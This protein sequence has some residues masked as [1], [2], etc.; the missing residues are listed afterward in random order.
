MEK[1]GVI[2]VGI[3][4]HLLSQRSGY[5]QAGIHNYI[6]QILQHLPAADEELDVTVFT[7]LPSSSHQARGRSTS[8]NWHTSR[9]ATDSP[10]SRILWEQF[11]QP[12]VLWRSQM[13]LLHAPAFVS[14]LLTPVPTLVT[15]HDL[16]FIRFP[17]LFR[18]LN[19]LYLSVMTRFSCRRARRIIAVSEATAVETAT[20]LDVP[21][22]RIDVIPHG[23]DHSRFRPL[24][25]ERIATFRRE[26]GL[27]DRYILFLGTLEPRKNLLALVEAYADVRLAHPDTQLVI[28]G[29]KGWYYQEIFQRVEQ[30]NLL[31]TVRFTGFVPDEELPLWY[32]AATVF[33]YPSLY[34][35]FGLPLL[36]AM[37]CGVPVIGADAS[38]T[39]DVVGTAGLLFSPNDDQALVEGLVS[40]LNDAT[41]RRQLSEQGL[42]R[43]ARFTWEAASQATVDSYRRALRQ[44]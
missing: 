7:H 39:P 25:D 29:G 2:H 42:C 10:W 14:P 21:L 20:L 17:E 15:I 13:D 30:L 16:S 4:A 36:E 40:L 11:V 9:W 44:A 43:A 34:E 28:A 41:L 23:V 19:R 1:Q 35:G 6:Q 32:N 26:K 3:N 27:P 24:S 5:R 8:L 31:N 33:V 38:C 22:E 37:S 12:W 18:P